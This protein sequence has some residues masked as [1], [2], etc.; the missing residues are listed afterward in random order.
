VLRK[1]V[2]TLKAIRNFLI[3][4]AVGA[5]LLL[6]LLFQLICVAIVVI[7]GGLLLL[8]SPITV[9]IEGRWRWRKFMRQFRELQAAKQQ[10]LD[11]H[12]S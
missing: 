12:P 7:G 6:W 8:I 5:A 9:W 3:L 2:I 1:A 4:L 11:K 10:P